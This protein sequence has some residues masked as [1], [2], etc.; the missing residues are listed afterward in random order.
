MVWASCDS[1]TFH[2][3]N[4]S[5]LTDQLYLAAYCALSWKTL[6][7]LGITCIINATLE[8]PTMA[9]NQHD[10]MQIAVEDRVAS[11]LYVYF[12]VVA[13]KIHNVHSKGGKVMI[14]CRAGMSRSASLC[15]AY[16][17]RHQGMNLEDAFNYVKKCRPI[18]HPNVGFMRQLREYEAKVLSR[19]SRQTL[20]LIANPSAAA[21]VKRKH[22]IAMG[23]G[24][25]IPGQPLPEL[26]Y[27]EEEV[28]EEI[29]VPILE[30][31][32]RRPKPRMMKLKNW[33]PE[34][35]MESYH[36]TTVQV[37]GDS[38]LDVKEEGPGIID[39]RGGGSLRQQQIFKHHR[40]GRHHSKQQNATLGMTKDNI[41]SVAQSSCDTTLIETCPVPVTDGSQFNQ[42]NDSGAIGAVLHHPTAPPR[43]KPFTK[44]SMESTKIGVSCLTI[45]F[46]MCAEFTS[47]QKLGNLFKG[48]NAISLSSLM[49]GCK[50]EGVLV[51]VSESEELVLECC[52]DSMSTD[53]P[54]QTTVI[55]TSSNTLA[56]VPF[57]TNN[58]AQIANNDSSRSD[59]RYKGRPNVLCSSNN[60]RHSAASLQRHHPYSSNITSS[61]FPVTSP[62]RDTE[63]SPTFSSKLLGKARTVVCQPRTAVASISSPQIYECSGVYR[64]Q[65]LPGHLTDTASISHI[66]GSPPLPTVSN[67]P[68]RFSSMTS[69]QRLVS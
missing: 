18:I 61:R 2:R 41:L 53:I 42:H 45:P 43:R 20:G 24:P 46:G 39:K 65:N 11:K 38:V 19:K 44:I 57:N 8:L 6:V 52:S 21:G 27:S 59:N 25:L 17:M 67:V 36:I 51:A 34:R 64:R 10:A 16:F 35:L 1:E 14:Y 49:T 26:V 69:S 37:L 50:G 9:N 66:K 28:C 56:Y 29:D 4:P 33:V 68:S 58:S 3:N 40:R 13:D 30:D 54:F 47:G 60:S 31:I 15:I 48:E 55:T 23:R 32:P 62:Q 5:V 63:S 22:S 12:D 7:E